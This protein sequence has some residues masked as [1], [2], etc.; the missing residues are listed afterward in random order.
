MLEGPPQQLGE[1]ER[2]SAWQVT[3]SPR[4]RAGLLSPLL[5]GGGVRPLLSDSAS[6]GAAWRTHSQS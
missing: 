3:S 2:G 4:L 6:L 5:P 1:V